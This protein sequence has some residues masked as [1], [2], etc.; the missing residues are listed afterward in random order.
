MADRIEF[1]LVDPGPFPFEDA[2]FDIV[3]SMGTIVQIPN[4]REVLSEALRVLRPGGI[5]A[6]NDWLRGWTGPLSKEM[7]EHGEK[8]GCYRCPKR[9]DRVGQEIGGGSRRG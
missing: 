2:S 9:A 8:A 7:I 3:F 4:K 6:G 5:L 1:R